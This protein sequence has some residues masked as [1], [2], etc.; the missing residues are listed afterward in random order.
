MNGKP[1]RGPFYTPA[2]KRHVLSLVRKHNATQAMRILRAG[3]NDPLSDLRNKK[4]VPLPIPISMP[5][6]LG[7]AKAEAITLVHG[8][9]KYKKAA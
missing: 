1:G 8:R 5:T 2:V 6:I 7:W 3:V 4:L 9:P